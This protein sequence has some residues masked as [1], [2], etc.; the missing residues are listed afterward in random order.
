MTCNYNLNIM[1]PYLTGL[2]TDRLQFLDN[3]H[4]PIL[5]FSA[6][7]LKIS[8]IEECVPYKDGDKDGDLDYCSG[9]S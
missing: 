3:A 5:H 7:Q 4:D 6:A 8:P 2:Q 9:E 1:P